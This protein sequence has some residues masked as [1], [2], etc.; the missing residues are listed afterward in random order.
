MFKERLLKFTQRWLSW[1]LAIPIL[2][3][4]LWAG[5]VWGGA[6]SSSQENLTLAR[7]MSVNT[8]IAQK[9][10]GYEVQRSYLGQLES[11]RQ[12]QL[13]FEFGGK[14]NR[15]LVDEGEH[16]SEG[17]VLAELDTLILESQLSSLVAQVA[18]SKS[19]LDELV[20]GPRK[21]VIE[22]AMAEVERW[23]AQ[24]KLARATTKRQ[25]RLVKTGATSNQEF[26]ES[27]FNE[28]AIDAQLAAVQARLD[29]LVNGTRAEQ[30]E[31]QRADWHR[32]QAEQQ[33][34]EIRIAK[35]QL[36]S[37]FTGIVSRRLLD[38]GTVVQ[39][40]QTVLSIFDHIQLEARIGIP[41]DTAARVSGANGVCD[42]QLIHQGKVVSAQLKAI[43]PEKNSETR[44][45]DA[46]FALQDRSKMP[47]IGELVELK[48]SQQIGTSG[49][50]LP[51]SSLVE[52]YRGLWGC[53]VLEVSGQEGKGTSRLRELELV[54]QQ[55]D[56]AYV[57]GAIKQ[58]DQVIVSGIHKL[59][60]NQWVEAA[61]GPDK[62]MMA[63]LSQTGE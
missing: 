48:V 15:V 45:V 9:A 7:P 55:G 19:R 24:Q 10:T 23:D 56:Y 17:Q 35:S 58:G 29:E 63:K 62:T 12:S 40:G 32:L 42:S 2:F 52:N 50:W 13:S 11:S 6:T 47:A 37:P 3:S 51:V 22:A 61:A 1:G 16:V 25:S 41:V 60:A 33:T 38:E 39:P 43:R 54:Y 5:G 57:S 26:D 20:D 21:E 18:A 44:T 53:Y 14:L 34:I 28:Q 59:V 30:I 49:I 31:A 27:L 46:I 36:I 4:I 8:I